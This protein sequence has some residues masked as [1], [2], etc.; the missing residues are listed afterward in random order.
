MV[1]PLP[2]IVHGACHFLIFQPVLGQLPI[3]ASFYP[4]ALRGGVAKLMGGENR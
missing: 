2:P 3:L 4:Y 1:V